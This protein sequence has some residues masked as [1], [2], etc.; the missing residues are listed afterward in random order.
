[1]VLNLKVIEYIHRSL[2]LLKHF[3]ISGTYCQQREVE[4][5][6]EDIDKNRGLCCCEAGRFPHMLSLNAAFTQRW[7]AW[8]VICLKFVVDGYSIKENKFNET[9]VGYDLRKRLI[10]L[11]IKVI[12]S[13]IFKLF[14]FHI[15]L[16]AVIFYAIRSDQLVNWLENEQIRQAMMSF[17]DPDQVDVDPSFTTLFDDDFKIG[18]GGVTKKTFI[19]VYGSWINLCNNK[20]STVKF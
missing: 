9:V 1:V 18:A 15:D 12:I 7:L 11:M 2:S 6:T 3:T 19:F 14:D 17:I 4:A 16:Q 20:R 10:S 5:I 13:L 8:E